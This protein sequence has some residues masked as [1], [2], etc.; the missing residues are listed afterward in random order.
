MSGVPKIKISE[1]VEELKILMK[2]QKTGLGYA[3]VQTLY[4][5]LLSSVDTESG[6]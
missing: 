1:S 5:L 2:K 4:L 6:L 3:K